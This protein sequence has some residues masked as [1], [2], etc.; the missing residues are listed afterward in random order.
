[1]ENN[2][3]D[4]ALIPFTCM[5]SSFT[6]IFP[7]IWVGVMLLSVLGLVLWVLML[8]DVVQRKVDEFPNKTEN[9]RLLWILVVVLAGQIGAAIYY[10]IVY[11]KIKRA[12]K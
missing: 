9:D 6:C 8:V 7:I 11:K 3:A 1:M 4:L 5:F 2:A 12:G 10:F